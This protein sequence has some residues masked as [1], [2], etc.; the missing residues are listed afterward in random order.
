MRARGIPIV[1]EEDPFRPVIGSLKA[2]GNNRPTMWQDLARGVR[3]EVDALNGAVVAEATRLGLKAPHNAALVH[4]IHSRE[5]QQFLNR[6]HITRTLGLDTTS[7]TTRES[8]AAAPGAPSVPRRR[9]DRGNVPEAPPLESTRR[10]KELVH[11]Y[12]LD[13]GAASD[14]PSRSVAACSGLA[15]VEIVRALGIAPYSPENH[16][17]LISARHEARQVHGPRV[18]RGLLAVLQFGDA[19]RHRRPAVAGQPAHGDPRDQ[20][21]AA[22]RRRRLLDQ[23]RPGAAA[24]VR[25][26]RLALRRAGRRPASAARRCTRWTPRSCTAPRSRCCG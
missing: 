12:Y 15:P 5:R 19:R 18:G 21:P 1:D 20:G 6:Q 3:T 24:V 8:P 16:A 10:L 9:A 2:L 26:L 13:L 23:H 17:V 11:A 22:P 14:D 4:F 7:G 25:V